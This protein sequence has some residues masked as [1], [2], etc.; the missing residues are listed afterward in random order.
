MAVNP[1]SYI[2]FTLSPV[3][4]KIQYFIC[5]LVQINLKP[6]EYQAKASTDL[7]NIVKIE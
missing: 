5:G 1:I 3:Q 4:I 2:L 7:R 6:F